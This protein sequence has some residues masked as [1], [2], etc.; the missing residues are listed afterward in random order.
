ME[1]TPEKE[2]RAVALV[3]AT[4]REGNKSDTYERIILISTA[5]GFYI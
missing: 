3:K 5:L 1:K 2:D 4:S